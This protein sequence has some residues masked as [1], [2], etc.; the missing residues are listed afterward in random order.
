MEDVDWVLRTARSVRRNLDFDRPIERSVL[1]EC[2]D[3][4]TQ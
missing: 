2:V 1:L 3:V 4:A